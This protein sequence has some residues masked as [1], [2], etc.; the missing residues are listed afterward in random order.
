MKLG[1]YRKFRYN[2]KLKYVGKC[3]Y[4]QEMLVKTF[5]G[6]G[7]HFSMCTHSFL[8][9]VRSWWLGHMYSINFSVSLKN[10]IRNT[11]KD[12]RSRFKRNT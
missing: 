4:S 8:T 10:F 3:H 1:N 9:N 12:Y 11:G 5:R 7:S 2:D 6:H